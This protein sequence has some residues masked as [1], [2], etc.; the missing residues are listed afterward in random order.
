MDWQPIST[1]PTGDKYNRPVLLL[2]R[3]DMFG[4]GGRVCVGIYDSDEYSKRGARP[5]WR[6][7]WGGLG[8]LYDRD[9]PPTHWLPMPT[10][11][12]TT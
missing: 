3:P 2:Y 7:F 8:V 1:A 10:K 9:N 11:P 6:S 5:F 12:D 4:G